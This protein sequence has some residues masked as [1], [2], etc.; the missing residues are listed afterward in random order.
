M[1]VLGKG[2]VCDERNTYIA[3]NDLSKRSYSRHPRR[4]IHVQGYLAHK[5]P[6][7]QDP[8]VRL[9]LKPLVVLG[10]GGAVSRERGTPVACNN[11]S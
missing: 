5:N 3:H 7:P 4:D 9:Y 6:P 10:G 8:T 1:V 11:L 2:A